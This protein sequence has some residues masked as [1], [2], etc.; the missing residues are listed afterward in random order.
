MQR[1]ALPLIGTHDFLSFQS[2][3]SKRKGT[4]RTIHELSVER[5]WIETSSRVMIGIMADGFLY[6]MVRNIVGTLVEVGR[7]R[8]PESW[9]VA[10]LAARDRRAAGQTAPPQGLYLDRVEFG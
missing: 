9:P 1:A 2:S 4:R 3:G 6:N 10:V 8:Q 5:R 7:G